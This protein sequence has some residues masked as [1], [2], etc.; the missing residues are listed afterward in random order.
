M[1]A[2]PRTQWMEVWLYPD[3]SN[4]HLLVLRSQPDGRCEV[5]DPQKNW[6]QVHPFESYEA[7]YYWLRQETYELVDGRMAL[8]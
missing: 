8:R 1:D 2:R 4:G 7:A 6:N 5:V 3:P